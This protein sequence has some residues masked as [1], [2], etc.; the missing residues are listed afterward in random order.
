M[1]KISKLIPED[2][3]I[4]SNIGDTA[5]DEAELKAWIDTDEAQLAGFTTEQLVVEV[6]ARTQRAVNHLEELV[7]DMHKVVFG[8]KAP[9]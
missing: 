8:E 9:F 1:S 7:I 2:F 4:E 3:T 6:N 5:Q